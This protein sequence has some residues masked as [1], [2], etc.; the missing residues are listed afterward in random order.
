MRTQVR[1]GG[2]RNNPLRRRSDVVEAWTALV[3]TVLLFVVAP[4]AGAAAGLWAH[5]Q[6]RTIA[7]T[8][9]ADRHRVPAQV[10]GN[11][12]S[13]LTSVEGT[14]AQTFPVE[15]RWTDPGKGPRT[16]TAE[17]PLGTVRGA[18]VDVWIDAKGHGVA[19]PAGEVAVWQH[20]LTIG[21]WTAGGVVAVALLASA[22]TRRVALRH[23]LAE[24]E[25]DWALTEPEWTQ[26]G[27]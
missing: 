26:R 15:V 5:D 24:W 3:V 17:V 14:R 20:T 16:A 6:A 13:Q 23:R 1:G 12:P 27:T 22:V 11:P 7:A 21:V 8:Q 2:R 19:P 9:R 4:V 18:M 25:R 10:I